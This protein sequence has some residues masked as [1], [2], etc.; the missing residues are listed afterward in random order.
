MYGYKTEKAA[1]A[2]KENQNRVRRNPNLFFLVDKV[3]L[4]AV[5]GNTTINA[6]HFT[7]D[8]SIFYL[9]LGISIQPKS[10]HDPINCS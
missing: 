9:F 3:S 5:K 7:G 8:S 2:S 4:R 1:C 6:R 10:F